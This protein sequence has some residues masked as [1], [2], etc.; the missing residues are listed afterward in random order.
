MRWP[1]QP[2]W[3][4]IAGKRYRWV[5][6]ATSSILVNEAGEVFG[7]AIGGCAYVERPI[8]RVGEFVDTRHAKRAVEQVLAERERRR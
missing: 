2:K 8:G 1:W 5:R 3:I 6:K 4:E 7:Q